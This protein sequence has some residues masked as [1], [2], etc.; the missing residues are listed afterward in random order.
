MFY[1]AK[2]FFIRIYVTSMVSLKN[3]FVSKALIMVL[4]SQLM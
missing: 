4:D 3:G 2:A 1:I